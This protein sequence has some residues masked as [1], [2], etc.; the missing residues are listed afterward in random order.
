LFKEWPREK[1]QAVE[2]V[3]IGGEPD[4]AES[5]KSLYSVFLKKTRHRVP[6]RI[7]KDETSLDTKMNESYDQFIESSWRSLIF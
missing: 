3:G 5:K 6:N 1:L 7:T 4:G 2:E